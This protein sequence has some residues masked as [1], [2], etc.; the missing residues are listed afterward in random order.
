[1]TQAPETV[2]QLDDLISTPVAR[3][4]N[5]VRSL[6]GRFAVL[7]AGGKMGFHISLMLQRALRAAGSSEPLITVSRFG[8]AAKREQFEKAG[9]EVVSADLAE[10]NQ[11]LALPD[12]ANVISLAAIKFGT[13]GR[14]DLLRRINVETS[15]LVTQRYHSSRIAMLSTG[16]VYPF[17]SPESGGCTEE[18]S[19]SAPGEYAQ[20]RLAQE[21]V[22]VE[23]SRR[24]GTQVAVV[25]LN[26][27]IDLRYGV[28]VDIA[29]K[30][31][32]RKPI[33][34]TMGYANVIWQGDAVAHIIQSLQIAA[35]PAVPINVTGPEIIRIRD[36]AEAFGRQF[37]VVPQITGTEQETAWLNNAA[38]SHALFGIPE[39]S[40][41]QMIDWVTAWLKRGG[42]TLDKPTHFETRGEGY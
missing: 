9:F 23:A 29:Q 11:V 6:S 31:F 36:L 37:R 26:Y 2:E 8:D 39:I 30:V 25:R 19:A 24:N 32:H 38:K 3:V 20:S 27:S 40:L 7:G 12:A 41:E 18:C 13:S 14:P 33:D 34:V 21:N 4:I 5:S 35:T 1:M 28:L 15:Q 16:C 42:P 17:V 22:F 10:Q